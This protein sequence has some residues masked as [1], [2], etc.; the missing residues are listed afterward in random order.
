MEVFKPLQNRQPISQ[1]IASQI[2][3]AILSKIYPPGSKLPSEAVLCEQFKVSRTPLREALQNLSAHGLITIQKGKG[4]FVNQIS[5][6]AVAGSLSKYLKQKLDKDYALD[7]IK[8]RQILEPA[9]AYSASLNRTDQDIQKLEE[10][11]NQLKNCTDDFI[12][13]AK[14][15]MQFHLLL[16][17]ASHN[18][19]VPLLLSS[20]YNLVPEFN[21]SIYEVN[22]DAKE[23]A[24]EL[25]A[26]ILN[27]V[28]N[29]DAGAA[30]LAMTEHLNN[31]E[32][33][34]RK[35]IEIKL[36]QHQNP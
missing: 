28:K 32:A 18:R 7:I 4:V 20:I 29:R 9:I 36:T 2:E 15:D 10:N 31:A 25:H 5:S 27:C 23:K 14:L 1:L 35:M 22:L 11:I 16:A 21:P 24:L 3:E 34:A 19:V 8:A 30:T 13:L 17:K 6:K 33:H 12:E 26:K